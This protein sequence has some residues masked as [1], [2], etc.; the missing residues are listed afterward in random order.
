MAHSS[1]YRQFLVC[2]NKARRS[3]LETSGDPKPVT[4]SRRK[5]IKYSIN[6]GL[7]LALAS[8]LPK[9]LAANNKSVAVIGAGLAGL[10][11]AYRLKQTGMVVDIYEAANRVGGRI[12]TV[13]G[14]VGQ[15]LITDLG[16]EL[17]NSDHADLL[18]LAEEFGIGLTSR[19]EPNAELKKVAYFFSGKV[20]DE[21]E[22]ADALRPLAGQIT[23][24]AEALDSDWDG[25]APGLDALSVADYLDRHQDL[26]PKQPDIRRLI[27]SVVAVE[28]GVAAGE[29]TALQLIFCL[30]VVDGSQVE[31]LSESDEAYVVN[32]GS[33]SLIHPLAG[34]LKDQ[35]HLNAAVTQIE[36]QGDRLRLR[37]NEQQPVDAD[38]VI[39]AV[40]PPALR[41]IDMQ[42]DLPPSFRTFINEVDLGRNEKIIAGVKQ[43]VWR[44]AQGFE[45]EAWSDQSVALM[46]DASL[47]QLELQQGALTFFLSADEVVQYASN[48]AKQ[49][50]EALLQEFTSVLPGL[51]SQDNGRFLR[52]AW[53]KTPGIMGAY[54]NFKPGQYTS[55][56]ADC[57]WVESEEEAGR[58][59]FAAGNVVFAG[60]HTS[61]EYYGFMNGAAQSGRLAAEYI[62][63]SLATG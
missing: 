2:L 47:R 5:F 21:V 15:D 7:S 45:I 57:L 39:L 11:A 26:I 58:V 48:S 53:H 1:L 60:E 4:T 10:N 61:D 23:R 3:N 31:L 35:I 34:I 17:V 22:I 40:P 13:T 33:E 63:N 41:K 42:M 52:T 24:D 19:I 56:V 18:A 32:G 36:K 51:T 37:I 50:G 25:V 20:C 44:Q 54:T 43:R 14:Q 12:H 49:Q 62:V 8:T 55:F 27:E 38:F 59:N 9:A 16:G 30:P 46:W 6:T 29:S 28:Y